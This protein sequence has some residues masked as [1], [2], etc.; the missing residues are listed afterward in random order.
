MVVQVSLLKCDVLS[1]FQDR[2]SKV[3]LSQLMTSSFK[4]NKLFSLPLQIH[5]TKGQIGGKAE[6]FLQQ[7]HRKSLTT[8]CCFSSSIEW[9]VE[10][11]HHEVMQSFS[12]QLASS[13]L[14]D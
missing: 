2:Y 9:E 12:F 10:E 14:M 6:S 1:P 3:L 5:R 4:G 7:A 13:V 8:Y 11:L